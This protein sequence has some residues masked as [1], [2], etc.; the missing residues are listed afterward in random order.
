MS[1]IDDILHDVGINDNSSSPSTED[2]NALSDDDINDILESNGLSDDSSEEAVFEGEGSEE[3]RENNQ[4]LSNIAQDDELE[5]QLY[6]Q[7]LEEVDPDVNEDSEEEGPLEEQNA[8]DEHVES[9]VEDNSNEIDAVAVETREEEI[10]ENAKLSLN[11][12][13]L[14]IDDSTS[15]FSGTEWYQS[16]RNTKIILAGV[17]GIGRI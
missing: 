11:S 13:T 5:H 12:P 2:V 15:R 3:E 17:G 7:A 9:T 16:I 10:P 1:D 6:Q 8:L 14:L 4:D